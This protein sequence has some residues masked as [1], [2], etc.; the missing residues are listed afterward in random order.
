MNEVR[1]SLSMIQC[2]QGAANNYNKFHPLHLKPKQNTQM[3]ERKKITMPF[4]CLKIKP[5][6]P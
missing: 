5:D 1:K 6:V 2:Q 4:F 3:N